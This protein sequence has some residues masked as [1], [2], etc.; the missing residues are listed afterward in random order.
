MYYMPNCLPAQ[1]RDRNRAEDGQPSS[2][3]TPVILLDRHLVCRNAVFSVYLDRLEQPDGKQVADYLSIIPKV[4]SGNNVTGVAVLPECDEKFGLIQVHRHP[5]GS[6]AWEL[7]RGFIDAGEM[8]ANAALREL[9]EE[10]GLVTSEA[11]L[12]PLGMIAPE[13]GLI[14]ARIQIFLALRCRPAIEPDASQELG[15]TAVRYF[16]NAE[17]AQLILNDEILDPCTI[18]AYLRYNLRKQN[19][20]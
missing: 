17:V 15:H 11:N 7:P 5:L 12:I 2:P 8:A 16:T 13:P 10:T 20:Y 18:A 19:I 4:H 3:K 14:V 1:R 9:K 6:V